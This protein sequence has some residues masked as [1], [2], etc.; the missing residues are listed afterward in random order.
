[1]SDQNLV[2]SDILANEII[3]TRLILMSGN[4]WIGLTFCRITSEKV[5]IPTVCTVLV[6]LL[7]IQYNVLHI[8]EIVVPSMT[9]VPHA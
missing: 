3:K 2:R 5:I 9:R 4:F 6:P 8:S 7:Y 1:M